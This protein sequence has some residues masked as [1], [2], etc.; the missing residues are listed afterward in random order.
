MCVAC[1]FDITS[2]VGFLRVNDLFVVVRPMNVLLCS[3]C[4]FLCLRFHFER[5]LTVSS[6]GSRKEF[7]SALVCVANAFESLTLSLSE[8]LFKTGRSTIFTQMHERTRVLF[9]KCAGWKMPE[10][11][12]CVFGALFSCNWRRGEGGRGVDHQFLMRLLFLGFG[13]GRPRFGGLGVRCRL[14]HFTFPLFS[15]HLAFSF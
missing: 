3:L 2:R 11:A 15:G 13:E 14:S 6:F 7:P 5:T 10:F 4:L 12:M 9:V 8:F 1:L